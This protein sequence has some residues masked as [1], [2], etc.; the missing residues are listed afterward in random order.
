MSI[1]SP[2]ICIFPRNI[3]TVESTIGLC[4]IPPA[5]S[6]RRPFADPEFRRKLS[7]TERSTDENRAASFD[8]LV[9]IV[10]SFAVSLM[11]VQYRQVGSRFFSVVKFSNSSL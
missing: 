9:V 7:E 10:D 11:D 4:Q 3:R 2:G 6:Q 5:E 8:G 1:L